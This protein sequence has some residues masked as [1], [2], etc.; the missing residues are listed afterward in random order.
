MR[1]VSPCIAVVA[2]SI[3]ASAASA[4]APNTF[5][6]ARRLVTPHS[7]EISPDG[8]TATFVVTRPDF[9]TNYNDFELWTVDLA[10]GSPRQLTT[11]RKVIGQTHWS[12]DG[13]SLA[14]LTPDSAGKM[15]LFESP[16]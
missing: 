14:F 11:S 15:Q 10:A 12:P 3:A 13:T 16:S 6:I 1:L 8:K 5:D 4:Q 7:V 9:E 2:L